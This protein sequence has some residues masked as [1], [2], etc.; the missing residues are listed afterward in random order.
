VSWLRS[1]VLILLAASPV[2][3]SGHHTASPALTHARAACREWSR[4]NAGISDSGARQQ[5]SQRFQQ[6]ATAA[7]GADQ[8]YKPLETAAQSWTFAQ[9]SGAS[10]D[11]LGALRSAIDQARAACAGVPAK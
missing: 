2:A 11:T 10:V 8:R 4:L 9:A 3:C 1:G 6:E 5:A 7:A